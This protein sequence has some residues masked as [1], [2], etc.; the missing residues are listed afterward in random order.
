[1][2]FEEICPAFWRRAV[3]MDCDVKTLMSLI[4]TNKFMY[5]QRK[6]L[7]R[8]CFIRLL[9]SFTS[10]ELYSCNIEKIHSIYKMNLELFV[11]NK[12]LQSWYLK[13]NLNQETLI[14]LIRKLFIT[15]NM[16]DLSTY[17]KNKTEFI[18]LVK[19]ILTQYI[20]HMQCKFTRK[21]YEYIY[22]NGNIAYHYTYNN[23]LYTIS[24]RQ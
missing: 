6:Y 18:A 21:P 24:L 9:E 19:K 10:N 22:L 4:Q 2:L 3:F 20:N 1:M 8:L 15:H 11:R 7:Y 17:L 5:K 23:E 12:V 14:Y 16:M 13:Y